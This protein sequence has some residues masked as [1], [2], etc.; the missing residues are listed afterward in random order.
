MWARIA[1][2]NVESWKRKSSANLLLCAESCLTS[3]AGSIGS[4]LLMGGLL[5][6]G[7][8]DLKEF[9]QPIAFH[10]PGRG[11]RSQD[12]F[13]FRDREPRRIR[14]VRRHDV[15]IGLPVGDVS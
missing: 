5:R 2:R 3:S 9:C 13:H 12:F 14:L 7:F 8:Q 11:K 4:S 6:V 1:R 15:V 10:G